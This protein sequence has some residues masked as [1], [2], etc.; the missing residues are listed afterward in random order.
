MLSL[1]VSFRSVF[2]DNLPVTYYKLRLPASLV[3]NCDDFTN[4]SQSQD[5]NLRRNPCL[6]KNKCLDSD[7]SFSKI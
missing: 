2:K 3:G 4:Y 5:R 7:P 1:T 6:K